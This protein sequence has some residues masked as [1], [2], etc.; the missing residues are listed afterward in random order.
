MVRM[1][2]PVRFRRGL[3]PKPAAQAGGQAGL[4]HA[5]G[6]AWRL[7]VPSPCQS[8]AQPPS[9]SRFSRPGDRGVTVGHDVLV[10]DRCNVGRVAQPVHDLTE[11][12]AGG[13]ARVPAVWRRSWTQ[14]PST[15]AA[16]VAGC[17]TR[18]LKLLRRS[19]LPWLLTRAPLA[20]GGVADQVFGQGFDHDGR[21]G[22][23]AAAVLGGSTTRSLGRGGRHRSQ[24]PL[25]QGDK[26]TTIQTSA[27]STDF[28]DPDTL[29][30]VLA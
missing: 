2:S 11:R 18:R 27:N 30:S 13:R 4:F 23:G 28:N 25:H 6:V 5:Q 12:G 7:R 26:S 8:G 17:Q 10:A 21:Q 24:W 3:H 14:R 16:R 20:T 19:C 29:P 9:V 22:D 1:G 15:P